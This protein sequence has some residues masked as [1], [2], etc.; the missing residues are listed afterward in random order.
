MQHDNVLA[1]LAFMDRVFQRP[2]T[3]RVA[4][5]LP[6]HHDMGLVG[7]LF[8]TLHDHGVG[9]FMPPGAFLANPALWLDVVHRYRANLSAAPTFAFEYCARKA[10]PD[11][12]WDLSCW[13]HVFV[14]SETVSL[15]ILNAF[16]TGS[17]PVA[18]PRDALRPVYG[19]PRPRC[20]RRAVLWGWVRYNPLRTRNP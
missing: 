4:S 3:V 10:S 9:V 15:P 14:G 2:E 13:K 6:L 17:G 1:N 19:L 18:W 12:A 16:W 5:W 20:W 8:T 11:P 7:H